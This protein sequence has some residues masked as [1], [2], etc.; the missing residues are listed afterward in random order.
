MIDPAR[1]VA[2]D[3]PVDHT[4][5]VDVEVEGVIG[6]RR[7]V[8]MAAQRLLPADDLAL[9]FDQRFAFRQVLHG[10]HAVAVDIGAAR[11]NAAAAGK[12]GFGRHR[13]SLL[14]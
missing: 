11:L 12:W 1:G 6:L 5:V 3:I 4:T 10:E 2:F 7:V 13:R 9:V 14:G 8:R